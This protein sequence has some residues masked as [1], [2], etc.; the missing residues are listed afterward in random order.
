M[1]PQTFTYDKPQELSECI[2]EAPTG[3][4]FGGWINLDTSG[5]DDDELERDYSDKQEILNL[6]SDNGT[7][8]TLYALWVN[9]DRGSIKYMIDG[10]EVSGLSPSSYLPSEP[11]ELPTATKD[12]TNLTRTG[13]TFSGWF[14]D[15][16]YKSATAITGWSSGSKEGDI[17]VYGKF[18]PVT[19]TITYNGAG[20]DWNWA[21]GYAAPGS[22]TIE[23]DGTL[24]S[25]EEIKKDY[26]D[27]NGWY[28]TSD[29]NGNDI[30]KLTFEDAQALAD[31]EN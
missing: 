28:S 5:H 2:F 25:S 20:T 29:F 16:G 19:Y 23:D 1:P 17:T 10:T 6:T 15:S 3:L 4:K 7:V 14:T 27:F 21:S 30:T 24:P 11:I 13:Y 8:I 26:Y 12:P 31:S 22:Y 9:K 18:E